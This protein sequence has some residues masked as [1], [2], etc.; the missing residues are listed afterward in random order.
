MEERT[1]GLK[2]FIG[3]SKTRTW[4]PSGKNRR[5]DSRSQSE[6]ETRKCGPES[7]RFQRK[8][9][10]VVMKEVLLE[11]ERIKNERY[12]SISLSRESGNF[13]K[14]TVTIMRF[15]GVRSVLN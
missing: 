2:D 5:H 10:C 9:R 8:D 11:S 4:G 7:R 14:L 6:A 15:C 3:L 1:I 12:K 13:F